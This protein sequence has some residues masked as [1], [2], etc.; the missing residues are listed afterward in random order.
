MRLLLHPLTLPVTFLM[1]H[2]KMF[3]KQQ[4]ALDIFL[5]DNNIEFGKEEDLVKLVDLL[6]K[7]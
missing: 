7:G 4:P 3:N 6:A 1:A 5:K 2:Y